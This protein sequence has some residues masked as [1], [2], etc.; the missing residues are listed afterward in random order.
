MDINK[1]IEIL[2]NKEEY[3]FLGAIL[4][5]ETQITDVYLQ[6]YNDEYK[7]ITSND[8]KLY[9]LFNK[10]VEILQFE[11]FDEEYYPT[12]YGRILEGLI[13]KINDVE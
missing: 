3:N 9:E 2:L 8:D 7:L 12:S 6:K 13:D 11:G 10:V 4:Q 1:S 5:K